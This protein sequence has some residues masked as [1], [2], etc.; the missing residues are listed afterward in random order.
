MQHNMQVSDDLAALF[1]QNLTFNP[2]LRASIPRD[3]PQQ[4]QVTS[5]APTK[6]IVYSISQH[7]NHSAHIARKQL[8]HASSQ[9]LDEPQR[10]ASEPVR[11]SELLN[12][13]FMLQQHG[14]NPATLT[15]SQLQLFRVAEQSQQLRLIELWSICPPSNSRDIHSL[16]WSSSS[17][18]H[19]EQLARLRYERQ[20]QTQT[21]TQ[22]QTMSLDG[23]PV[24][25]GDSRWLQSSSSEPYMMSGYEELMRREEEKRAQES[26]PKNVYNHFGNAIGGSCY[27][28]A[29]DP[30][31][32]GPESNRHQHMAMASQYGAFEQQR[33]AG[34]MDTMDVL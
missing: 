26:R 19:E 21:Q 8:S 16:A 9:P 2:E 30:V 13:E 18:E 32:L 34:D 20:Q 27:T 4:E 15:P 11:G 28:G 33:D 6:P 23:T 24:Q 31:Y 29:T 25:T 17:M 10:R 7:Y 14:I 22:T 1:A 12:S 5:H 3:V